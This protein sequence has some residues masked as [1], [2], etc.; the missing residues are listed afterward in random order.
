VEGNEPHGGHGQVCEGDKAHVGVR[1]GIAEVNLLCFRWLSP[2]LKLVQKRFPT[3]VYGQAIFSVKVIWLHFKFNSFL[4]ES[5]H[6]SG[7][8]RDEFCVL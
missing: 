3:F 4:D 1:H 6:I 7:F 2:F 8:S 5:I